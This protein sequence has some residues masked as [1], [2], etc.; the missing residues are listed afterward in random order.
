V[1]ISFQSPLLALGAILV[2]LVIEQLQQHLFV[3]VVMA[4]A[5]GLNPVIIII[6]FL[7]AAKLI[8]FWGILLAIP[9]AVTLAEF[10]KDFRK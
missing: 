5:T 3:P 7:V 2:Y 1:L 4:K 6:A 9:I 8:G 10:V